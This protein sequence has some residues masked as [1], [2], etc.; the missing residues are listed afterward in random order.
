MPVK[1][2]QIHTVT[3]Q[4][5]ELE[6]NYIYDTHGFVDHTDFFWFGQEKQDH[7]DV[8]SQLFIFCK[9]TWV[10]FFLRGAL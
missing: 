5:N 9:V 8:L 2:S 1:S 3:L 6:C 4:E 10:I 7:P